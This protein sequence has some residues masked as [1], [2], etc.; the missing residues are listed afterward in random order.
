[1]QTYS[2]GIH[3]N[4]GLD[5]CVPYQG[6]LSSLQ[7]VIIQ[8]GHKAVSSSFKSMSKHLFLVQAKNKEYEMKEE[9]LGSYHRTE[10]RLLNCYETFYTSVCEFS[11]CGCV[12][13]SN[14][15]LTVKGHTVTFHCEIFTILYD[16]VFL[17]NWLLQGM[18]YISLQNCVSIPNF[19]VK[20]INWRG[21]RLLRLLLGYDFDWFHSTRNKQCFLDCVT[22][23]ESK[24]VSWQLQD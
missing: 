1:M 7:P 13:V 23:C 3:N 15:M 12:G 8:P 19:C 4:L 11:M 20:M 21:L 5:F 17:P 24:L 10:E 9:Q 2:H 22:T 18:F 14:W 16:N 6:L